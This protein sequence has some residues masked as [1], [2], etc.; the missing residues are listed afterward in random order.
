MDRFDE[1]LANYR[2]GLLDADGRAELA[3][4]VDIDPDCRDAFV[5]AMSEQRIRRL[6]LERT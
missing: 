5:A 3:L 1:L 4:Y 6:A 2:D